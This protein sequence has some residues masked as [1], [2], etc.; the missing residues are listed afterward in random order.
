MVMKQWPQHL[1]KRTLGAP[2]SYPPPRV[3]RLSRAP[4]VWTTFNAGACGAS[5]ADGDGNGCAGYGY[6]SVYVMRLTR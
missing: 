1:V 5:R 4:A 3:Y 6:A 2:A